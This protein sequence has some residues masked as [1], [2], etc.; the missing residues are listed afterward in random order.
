M[1]SLLCFTL[2]NGELFSCRFLIAYELAVVDA[3]VLELSSRNLSCGAF[4]IEPLG[5]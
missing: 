3:N 2:S 4:V 5:L 1:K